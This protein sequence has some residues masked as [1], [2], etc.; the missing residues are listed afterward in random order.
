MLLLLLVVTALVYSA[1]SHFNAPDVDVV[2]VKAPASVSPV[3]SKPEPEPQAP[4][5]PP[6]QPEETKDAPSPVPDQT[7]RTEE[8]SAVSD[9]KPDEIKPE[10]TAFNPLLSRPVAKDAAPSPKPKG[11][12]APPPLGKWA[13]RF[14]L[15]VYKP[16]CDR[17]IEELSSRGINAFMTEGV[18][19]VTFYKV[20]VGPYPTQTHAEEAA[21]KF[22][23]KKLDIAPFAV[24]GQYYLGA[25]SFI[26]P[27]TQNEIMETAQS[28]GYH[29]ES[30]EGKESRKVYKVYRSLFFDTKQ[31]AEKAMRYHK[32]RGLACMI[33]KGN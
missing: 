8:P 19:E 28:L 11:L 3:A 4:G 9:V 2:V 7:A 27:K 22:R 20:M 17:L 21:E 31:A 26:D 32:G 14:G 10:E 5:A 1:V 24:D 13:L 16:N 29:A 23:A 6:S 12:Q 30:A 15:C 18:A 33:E 25:A